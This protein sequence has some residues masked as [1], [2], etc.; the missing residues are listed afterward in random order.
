M[1]NH[2]P[3]TA[4]HK[5]V[6][7]PWSV[8]IAVTWTTW[9]TLTLM[10]LDTWPMIM[11]VTLTTRLVVML[12]AL[13]MRIVIRLSGCLSP[14]IVL[15]FHRVG[16]VVHALKMD[17]GL[18][19]TQI[20]LSINVSMDSH[21]LLYFRLLSDTVLYILSQLFFPL[22]L[23][24]SSAPHDPIMPELFTPRSVFKGHSISRPYKVFQAHSAI[25]C[26]LVQSEHL[27]F[28]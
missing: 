8:L 22:L 24:T 13:T 27:T 20:C 3:H 12:M 14:H 23:V 15:S 6:L 7:S 18:S 17:W 19:Y 2:R 21:K 28:L 11:M 9:L 1:R 4:S 25:S 5:G 16:R 26:L 10:T